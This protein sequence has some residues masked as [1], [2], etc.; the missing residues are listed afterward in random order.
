[1]TKS[2][3]KSKNA[4]VIIRLDDA[5]EELKSAEEVGNII[6]ESIGHLACMQRVRVHCVCKCDKHESGDYKMVVDVTPRILH[7][8]LRGIHHNVADFSVFGIDFEKNDTFERSLEKHLP[9]GTAQP[10]GTQ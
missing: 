5:E 9:M 7:Q 4:R 6:F 10:V 2:N 3:M 8:L 1:M